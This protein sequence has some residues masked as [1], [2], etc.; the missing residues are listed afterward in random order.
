MLTVMANHYL[1]YY[2]SGNYYGIANAVIA[3]FFVISGYGIYGSLEKRFS[4]GAEVG[5]VVLAF[6]VDRL[7]R[8]YPLFLLAI[9][10]QSFVLGKKYQF[11]A[12]L[13]MRGPDQFW[14]VTA[15]MLCYA[16]APFFSL[17][18]QKM[19]A[20]RFAL[21]LIGHFLF[22]NLFGMGAS[23]AN[24]PFNKY[25]W[26]DPLAYRGLFL[27][28][29]VL[30]G[31][32]MCFAKQEHALSLKVPRGRFGRLCENLSLFAALALLL[33][34]WKSLT[35]GNLQNAEQLK[36][37]VDVIF[38]AVGMYAFWRFLVNG[39]RIPWMRFFGEYSLSIY[40]F[41]LVYFK[42]LEAVYLIKSGV[43]QSVFWVLAG[44]PLF[45]LLCMFSERVVAS[46][47]QCRLRPLIFRFVGLRPTV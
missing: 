41:H 39:I 28:Y 40:L 16:V 37:V 38:Y 1:N 43:W 13:G 46:R 11:I 5:K 15:I 21:V 31:L 36:I 17:Y 20:R 18:L 2:V 7:L 32:G 33:V 4:S 45:F 3:I 29:F 35:I 12:Y 19:G 25:F 9:I 42:L 23:Y 30:F 47:L 14:F 34:V 10:I 44:L 6:W 22:W 8:I 26:Q 27:S 24:F